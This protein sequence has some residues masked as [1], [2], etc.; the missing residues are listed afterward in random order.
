LREAPHGFVDS[1][2]GVRG[3]AQNR[4]GPRAVAELT[5]ADWLAVGYLAVAAVGLALGF[6]KGRT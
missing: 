6:R 1:V 4:E 3:V 5:R 2:R